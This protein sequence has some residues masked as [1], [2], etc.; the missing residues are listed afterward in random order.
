[1]RKIR[2]KAGASFLIPLLRNIN[3]QLFLV[4][5]FRP[6]KSVAKIISY[7]ETTLKGHLSLA[8]PHLTALP[9]S[10]AKLCL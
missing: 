8:P 2:L 3:L 10:P 7:V 9:T 5:Y 6:L 1:M 4:F